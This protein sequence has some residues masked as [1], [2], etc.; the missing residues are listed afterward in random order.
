M[1]DDGY[2]LG[3]IVRG[4]YK[5]KGGL[6]YFFGPKYKVV[7]D[8]QETRLKQPSKANLIAWFGD[9]GII[10]GNWPLIASAQPFRREE[11]PVPKFQRLDSLNSE[12]GWLVEYSQDSNGL[13]RPIRETPCDAK[14][15][16]GYPEDDVYG[17][18]AVENVLSKLLSGK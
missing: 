15:L 1:K 4:N 11:W 3:I 2:A 12:R 8:E 17:Y 9:L 13:E 7:P 14:D 16:V 10:W 18:K 5:T 6:G